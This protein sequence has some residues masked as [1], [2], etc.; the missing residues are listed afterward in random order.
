MPYTPQR[1]DAAKVRIA[2]M[3]LLAQEDDATD[4]GSYLMWLED[5][6]FEAWSVYDYEPTGNQENGAGVVASA[7]AARLDC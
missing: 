4:V 3:R 7:G 6:L 2:R 1:T 5:R